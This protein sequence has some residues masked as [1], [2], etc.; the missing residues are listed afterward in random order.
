MRFTCFPYYTNLTTTNID[1]EQ[2]SGCNQELMVKEELE[3]LKVSLQKL[4]E[5]KEALTQ[6]VSRL[7]IQVA[8]QPYTVSS[9]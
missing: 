3:Q 2:E 8:Q 9:F 5:T 6:S 1:M 7:E 4:T